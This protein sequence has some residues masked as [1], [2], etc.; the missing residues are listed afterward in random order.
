M[1][2]HPRQPSW[3]TSSSL[4]QGGCWPC[5]GRGLPAAAAAEAGQLPGCCTVDASIGTCCAARM[6]AATQLICCPFPD[7]S[8]AHYTLSSCYLATHHPRSPQTHNKQ[9]W[10]ATRPLHC[11]WQY[12]RQRPCPPQP[13]PARSTL[14]PPLW[15]SRMCPRRVVRCRCSGS[16]LGV[17]R[18]SR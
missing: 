12:W 8:Q 13:R 2:Q 16:G 17:P 14:L 3:N 6:Q 1:P 7:L 15:T 11:C 5:L 9:P 18:C 10:P 4:A